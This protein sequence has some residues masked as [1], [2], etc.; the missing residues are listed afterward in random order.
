MASGEGGEA[1]VGRRRAATGGWWPELR[2]GERRSQRARQHR[3]DHKRG[4]DAAPLFAQPEPGDHFLG[5]VAI[6]GGA[7]V[8]GIVLED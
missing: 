6:G 1:G 8:V 4:A 3:G 7:R 2:S 5:Q